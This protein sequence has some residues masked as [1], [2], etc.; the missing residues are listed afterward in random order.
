MLKNRSLLTGLGIGLILGSVMLQ[1]VH[2]VQQLE[3][4]AATLT[5]RAAAEQL[6]AEELREIALQKGFVLHAK[7]ETLFT[8]EQMEEA[9]SK[10]VEA[11]RSEWAAQAPDAA[12][13]AL[14]K[15]GVYIKPGL[16]AFSVAARLEEFGVIADRDRF[17]ESLAQQKLHTKIQFGYFEFAPEATLQEVIDTVTVPQ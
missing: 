17:V 4:P 3:R 12:K 7:E 14:Y 15:K 2:A 6:S 9:R 11:A 1:S 8:R 10:A 13:P 16:D 5:P